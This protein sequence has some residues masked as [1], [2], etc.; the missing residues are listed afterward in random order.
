MRKR[1]PWLRWLVVAGLVGWAG[2]F[3]HAWL[4]RAQEP[5]LPPDLIVETVASEVTFPVTLRFAPDGRLFFTERFVGAEAPVTG[6]IRVLVNGQLQA[7]PFAVVELTNTAPFAEKGLLG[8]A[9]DPDFEANGYVYAYRTAGPTEEV[10]HERGQVLRYTAVLTDS[11]W[12]GMDMQVVVD[13]LPV[14]TGCCHNGGMIDFGPDGKLYVSVGEVDQRHK[15]QDLTH[16]AGKLLRFN[17]DGSIPADN[18]FMDHP[19]ADPAVYAYGLRNVFGFDWHPLS[20]ALY[21]TD[22]GPHCNDELNQ[23]VAGGNYGWPLSLQAGRCVDPGPDYVAP[24]L[25]FDPPPG[26]TEVRYYGAGRLARYTGGLFIGAWNTGTLYWVALPE[27][28]GEYTATEVLTNCGQP[29]GDHNMVG[30]APASDG[31]LYFSCQEERFP[32]PPGTGAI[33]RLT[34]K[35]HTLFLPLLHRAP[36]LPQGLQAPHN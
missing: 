10:P 32:A 6:T 36:A 1:N 23:V 26:L 33:Y 21:A 12:I 2:L 3:S 35:T 8:L 22:N 30:L 9:L 16:R 34:T 15:V 24:L 11:Q 28:E 25:V 31:S 4:V 20:G 27:G 5:T 18:P 7:T 14:S 13:D 29:A 17:P 19:A